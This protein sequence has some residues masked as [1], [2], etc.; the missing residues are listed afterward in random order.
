MNIFNPDSWMDVAL[1]LAVTAMG[2]ATTWITAKNQA[3]VKKLD[4]SVS[5]GHTRP[6]RVD[7]D[8]M[9]ELL[10]HIRR[11]LHS[12]KSELGHI[13]AELRDERAERLDLD[14]RVE[15]LRRQKDI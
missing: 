8:D 5:N 2:V 11:D 14:H 9:R 3:T 15:R 1:I 13:R 12:V 4:S 6:L 10:D 7:M